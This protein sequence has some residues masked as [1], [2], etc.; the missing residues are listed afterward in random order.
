MT[1]RKCYQRFKVET[2]LY[3]DLNLNHDQ[4]YLTLSSTVFRLSPP[5]E[6]NPSDDV[7][8][9]VNHLSSPVKIIIEHQDPEFIYFEL[10]TLSHLCHGKQAQNANMI[11][12]SII[13]L[14]K[15]W[16]FLSLR[17]L[18]TGERRFK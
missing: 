8:D 7:L 14:S 11:Y 16:E 12:Y 10:M 4:L 6:H 18:M 1:Q 17:I 5:P 2:K 3:I 9:T 13:P 15:L